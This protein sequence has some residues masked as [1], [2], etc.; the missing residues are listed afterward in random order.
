MTRETPRGRATLVHPRWLP[1]D[2]H[3]TVGVTTG[4]DLTLDKTTLTF[5]STNWDGADV[6]VTAAEDDRAGTVSITENKAGR[7]S[8]VTPPTTPR[9]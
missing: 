6:T 8:V 5:T 7:T 9:R 3:V 4:T 1:A 2:G